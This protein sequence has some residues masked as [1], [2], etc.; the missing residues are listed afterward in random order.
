MNYNTSCGSDHLLEK[1]VTHLSNEV[2]PSPPV[3]L[4]LAYLLPYADFQEARSNWR[5]LFFARYFGLVSDSTTVEEALLA[6]LSDSKVPGWGGS[7]GELVS[8][9]PGA[10]EF[11][12][13]RKPPEVPYVQEL[14]RVPE[15]QKY[16]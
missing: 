8:R 3:A 7:F 11:R 2:R 9:A 5:P 15:V 10:G 16:P 12:N 1:L 14:L 6:L 13:S 4:Q